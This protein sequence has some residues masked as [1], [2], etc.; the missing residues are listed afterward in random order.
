MVRVSLGGAG[1]GHYLVHCDPDVHESPHT[2]LGRGD[3]EGEV[4]GPF[5]EDAEEPQ[6]T[7]RLPV[8]TDRV[9]VLGEV[10]A[11]RWQAVVVDLAEASPGDQVVDQRGT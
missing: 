4:T 8:R 5:G 11:A 6:A 9:K 1:A 10:H 7:L 3:V 2:A